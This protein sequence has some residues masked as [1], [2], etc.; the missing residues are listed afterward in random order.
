MGHIAYMRKIHL[1]MISLFEMGSVVLEMILKL[2]SS[3]YFLKFIIKDPL[4]K[5]RVPLFKQT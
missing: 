1:R 3:L 4:V 2:N 5:G